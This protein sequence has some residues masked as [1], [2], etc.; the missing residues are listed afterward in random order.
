MTGAVRL[1]PRERRLAL[2]A[3]VL[4]GSWMCLSWIMQPLWER[5]RELRLRVT[6]HTGKLA[7]LN[8]LVERAPSIEREYQGVAA[9]LDTN[10]DEQ[11]QGTFLSELE[12]LS[13]D[14]GVH[15]NLKPRPVK[16]EE[17]L[18]RLEVEL[19]VEGPQP[20]L[21]QFL[22]AL[23]R[24]PKLIAVDRLRI[25]TIPGKDGI[26]RANLVIQKLTLRQKPSAD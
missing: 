1:Q 8:R 3:A 9:Y 11:A 23:L 4:I 12:G 10:G 14:A 19:D 7:A 25:A 17:R 13:R 18:S 21:M 22:D 15:L 20:N 16:E 2:I 6:T 5:V 26:L 24:M